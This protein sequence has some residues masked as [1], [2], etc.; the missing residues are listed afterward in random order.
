MSTS[1]NALS[2]AVV[3]AVLSM[4][5]PPRFARQARAQRRRCRR[6]PGVRRRAG[7]GA[8]PRRRQVRQARTA[9]AEDGRA[10]RADAIPSGPS[11]SRGPSSNRKSG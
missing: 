4:C 10:G 7:P 3:C 6:R 9:H 2:L 8:K 1:A 11:S 5:W